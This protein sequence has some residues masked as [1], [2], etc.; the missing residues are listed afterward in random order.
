[1]ASLDRDAPSTAG[2]LFGLVYFST[3]FM[4][5]AV[6]CVGALTIAPVLFS[7][8]WIA[9]TSLGLLALVAVAVAAWQIVAL[10]ALATDAKDP[11]LV[12]VLTA[13]PAAVVLLIGVFGAW[14]AFGWLQGFV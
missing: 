12:A 14:T 2:A 5:A 7:Q 13:T 3:W 10:V 8:P 9:G 1:M 4:G 11:E 6:V